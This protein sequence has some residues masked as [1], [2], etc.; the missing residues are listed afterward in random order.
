MD[1]N[2]VVLKPRNTAGNDEPDVNGGGEEIRDQVA[3]FMEAWGIPGVAPFAFCIFFSKLVAYT[4]LYCLPFYISHKVIGGE[5]LSD[6][7]VRMLSSLFDVSEVFGGIL[8][9]HISDHLD[10]RAITAS[11]FMYCAIPALFLY[12]AYGSISLFCNAAPMIATSLFLNR[13]YALITTAI[14]ANLGTHGSLKGNSRALA[15]VTGII[16]ETGSVG[17]AI[18]PHLTGCLSSRSLDSVFIMLMVA[19]LIAGLLLTKL[20]IAEVKVKLRT[21]SS[22]S[23]E[24]SLI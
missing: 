10:A 13:P 19:A 2:D 24:E 8:A 23:L 16:D 5:Y 22:S 11:S 6:L 14:S 7:T 18:R 20:V 21:R 17:A 9:G 12:H 15:T 4:F 3:G 1:K